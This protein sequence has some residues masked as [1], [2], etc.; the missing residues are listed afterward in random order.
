[1]RFFSLW[2]VSGMAP[3]LLS[4]MNLLTWPFLFRLQGWFCWVCC[5]SPMWMYSSRLGMAAMVFLRLLSVDVYGVC[6]SRNHAVC[7]ITSFPFK[8]AIW[9]YT[10]ISHFQTHPHLGLQD[11]DWSWCTMWMWDASSWQYPAPDRYS[12]PSSDGFWYP[13][14]IPDT[15]LYYG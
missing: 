5:I 15:G 3:L 14:F 7:L 10:G 2:N 13:L 6:V 1:M 8:I 12:R 4:A 11:S 9:W